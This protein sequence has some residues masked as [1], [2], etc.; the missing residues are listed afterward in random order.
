MSAMGVIQ[1]PT[2][3]LI[4]PGF[5]L[6]KRLFD[7]SICFMLLPV[8][9]PLMLV[10]AFLI[11]IDSKGPIFFKQIRVGKGGEEFEIY[12]FRT[13]T[14]NFDDSAHKAYMKQ[15]IN[16]NVTASAET[17]DFK[18]PSQNQITRVGRILRKT[19]I[20]ELPQLINVIKGDMS[21]VGPRPNVVWE[22]EEY[23][24]WHTE[25]LEVKPGITGL[26]Q[27]K[28]RSNISF[29]IIVDY[30]VAYVREQSFMLDVKILWWTFLSVVK[31]SGA[32]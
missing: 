28:G 29:G 3:K 2:A 16:G 15:Y 23:E 7:L 4:N 30:D 18:P 27:V 12:K 9:A 1:R 6:A 11:A 13:M 8:F 22:V 19:S 14:H 24:P 32:S 17:G 5:Q 31:R 25:R 10:V 20:D 21:L 26:A